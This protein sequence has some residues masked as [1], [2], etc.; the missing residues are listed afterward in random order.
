MLSSIDLKSAFWQILSDQSSAEKTALAVHGRGLFQFC[1]M[2]FGIGNAQQVQQ[3]L[4]NLVLE[5]VC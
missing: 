1:V 5:P 4:M 2:F 3:R